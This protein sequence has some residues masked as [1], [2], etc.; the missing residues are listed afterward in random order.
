MTERFPNCDVHHSRPTSHDYRT[1]SYR[2]SIMSFLLVN[3]FADD[4]MV[5]QFLGD[6]PYPF[7]ELL[8]RLFGHLSLQNGF[9]D[10]LFD[11]PPRKADH[12]IF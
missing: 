6:R 9:L 12:G 2:F 4:T 1:D 5:D 3:F 7:P 10:S 11:Y 8:D